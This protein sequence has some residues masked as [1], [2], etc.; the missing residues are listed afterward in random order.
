MD[1]KGGRKKK[2]KESE[3]E[4]KCAKKNTNNTKK[5]E[6]E[7][8]EKKANERSNRKRKENICIA[9]IFESSRRQTIAETKV[10]KCN[11]MNHNS[12]HRQSLTLK[13]GPH[14]IASVERPWEDALVS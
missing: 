1:G 3:E 7:K 9:A 5:E 2:K 14:R 12:R 8:R 4:E 10:S 6:K 11:P 13:T